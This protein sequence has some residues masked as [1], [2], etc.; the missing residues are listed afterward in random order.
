MATTERFLNETGVA[1]LVEQ[2]LN[3]MDTAVNSAITTTIN[4]QSTNATVPGT[5]A[6]YNFVRGL[7]GNISTASFVIVPDGQNR[8]VITDSN[9]FYLWREEATSPWGVYLYFNGDWHFLTELDVRLDDFWAKAE[10]VPLTNAQIL[11][12]LNAAR[13]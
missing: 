10:L 7:V 12:I 3:D 9:K 1:F 5:L 11:A 13:A 4:E 6:L 8:P 2:L